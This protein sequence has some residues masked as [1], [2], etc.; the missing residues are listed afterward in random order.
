MLVAQAN[1]D[2]AR[3]STNSTHNRGLN[4][5]FEVFVGV[6]ITDAG[7]FGNS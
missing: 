3:Q 4:F 2:F 7:I 1:Q 5:P 6:S